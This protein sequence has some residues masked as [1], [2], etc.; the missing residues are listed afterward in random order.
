VHAECLLAVATST[1]R[2][3][4]AGDLVGNLGQR[5]VPTVVLRDRHRR[6]LRQQ[7]YTSRDDVLQRLSLGEPTVAEID[8][9]DLDAGPGGHSEPPGDLP[10]PVVG[11]LAAL[12]NQEPARLSLAIAGF[13]GVYSSARAFIAADVSVEVP[14]AVWSWL[15]QCVD[16]DAAARRY[17]AMGSIFVAWDGRTYVFEVV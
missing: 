2:R 14:P 9:S 7:T 6:V 8:L 16:F 3:L 1:G 15:E 12:V 4:P 17:R 11:M 10:R 5:Q 13:R